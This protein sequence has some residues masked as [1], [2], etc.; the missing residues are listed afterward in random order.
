MTPIRAEILTGNGRR[1]ARGRLR[2]VF[3]ANVYEFVQNILLSA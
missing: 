1:G 2:S 3:S